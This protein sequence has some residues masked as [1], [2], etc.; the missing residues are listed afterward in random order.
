M[1][2]RPATF[3][4]AC[5]FAH[6]RARWDLVVNAAAYVLLNV[7]TQYVT[8]FMTKHVMLPKGLRDIR[9]EML[10]ISEHTLTWNL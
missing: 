2:G 6:R 3:D 4:R 1:S 8:D 10:G 5:M 9:N 7:D